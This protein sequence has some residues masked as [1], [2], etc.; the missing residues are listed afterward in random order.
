VLR[1]VQLSR[2]LTAQ[3]LLKVDTERTVSLTSC[4]CDYLFVFPLQRARNV[5]PARVVGRS[6][7][8]ARGSAVALE[9]AAGDKPAALQ[10]R[11][12]GIGS[13]DG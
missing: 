3:Q 4:P 7:G 2:V 11:G 6:E 12:R 8:E 13:K 5:H 1:I 10:P 9:F